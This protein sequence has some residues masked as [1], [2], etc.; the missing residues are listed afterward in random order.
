MENIVQYR[1]NHMLT[2]TQG[3]NTSLARSVPC[4]NTKFVRGVAS[5][6]N[7]KKLGGFINVVESI[8]SIRFHEKKKITLQ[9]FQL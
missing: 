8:V 4:D 3:L 9:L 7:A 6:G 5:T 2:S 1:P